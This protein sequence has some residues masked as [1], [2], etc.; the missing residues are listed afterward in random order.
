MST[1]T[2]L[3]VNAPYLRGAYAHDL[4]PN[5]RMPTWPVAFDPFDAYAPLVEA[6]AMG[7]DAVRMWLCEGGEGIE[8]DGAGAI[9]GVHPKLLESIAILQEGAHLAGTRI[10]WTLLDANSA[11]R[12]GDAITRSILESPDQAARFADEVAAPIAAALDVSLAVGLDIVSEP[13]TASSDTE[14]ARRDHPGSIGWDSMG[15]AIT[16]ARRAARA[17]QP[18][19]LCTAGVMP[20]ALPKLLASGA[21]LDAIDIHVYHSGGGLP[22]REQLA[23]ECNAPQILTMPLLIGEAGIP[24]EGPPEEEFALKNY[25]FNAQKLGFDAVFLWKLE[26][27][28]LD[29]KRPRRPLTA[30]GQAVAQAARQCRS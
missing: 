29:P 22:S 6:R 14:D 30:L 24:S 18:S 2:L 26:G 9:T 13:E 7:L 19:L 1:R 8:I 21:E 11:F 20:W 27:D 17:A 23:T 28:L 25:L 15:T 12:D 4:A 16:L 10:Y 5:A 3:G